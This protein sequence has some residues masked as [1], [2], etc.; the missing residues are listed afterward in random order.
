MSLSGD[1]LQN[2]SGKAVP[3]CYRSQI[4]MEWWCWARG[5]PQLMQAPGE[6]SETHR[7]PSSGSAGWSPS[8]Q[9]P[10]LEAVLIALS[11]V[12]SLSRG[13]PVISPFSCKG[14]HP[15]L[16]TASLP[17]T[18]FFI[19]N[20]PKLFSDLHMHSL[21]PTRKP[22][23]QGKKIKQNKLPNLVRPQCHRDQCLLVSLHFN[24]FT[25]D[26][27]MV[28]GPRL[29]CGVGHSISRGFLPVQSGQSQ[30]LWLFTLWFFLVIM[31]YN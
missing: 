26:I 25:S 29:F 15:Y 17:L 23:M 6:P 24:L 28:L 8:A 1:I 2:V 30:I 12:L 19:L 20:F 31:S 18:F 4:V 11:L 14:H 9:M 21:D 16:I 13:L 7:Q 3:F 5:H 22:K 27:G 10:F